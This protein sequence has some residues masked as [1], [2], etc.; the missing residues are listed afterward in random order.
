MTLTMADVLRKIKQTEREAARQLS[1]AKDEA[2]KIV[3]DARKKSAEIISQASDDSV[4]NTQ[5]ILDSARE[6]AAKSAEKVHKEFVYSGL[7]KFKK[8]INNRFFLAIINDLEDSAYL[9]QLDGILSDIDK[10]YYRD[11]YFLKDGIVFDIIG[12]DDNNLIENINKKFKE[13]NLIEDKEVSAN[14]VISEKNLNLIFKSKNFEEF[15]KFYINE[16]N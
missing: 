14:F 12:S 13:V 16:G 6:D 15:E 11:T 8:N 5:S 4:S 1:A 9:N 7:P 10:K 2:S 3:S